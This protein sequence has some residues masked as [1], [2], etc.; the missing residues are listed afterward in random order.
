VIENYVSDVKATFIES[1]E[2]QLFEKAKTSEK[3][4]QNWLDVFHLFKSSN[5]AKIQLTIF[6]EACVQL[7]DIQ[8]VCLFIYLI[9]FVHCFV[10]LLFCLFFIYLKEVS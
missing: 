3:Q 10:H 7:N 6:P 9:L 4:N 8:R 2:K 1:I 5:A